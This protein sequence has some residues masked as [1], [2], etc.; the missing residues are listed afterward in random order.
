MD[1]EAP[2]ARRGRGFVHPAPR[3]A[4]NRDP[5]ARLLIHVPL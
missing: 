3:I 5:A 4:M 2:S 1:D